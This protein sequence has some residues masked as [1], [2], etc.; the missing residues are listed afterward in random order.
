M[1][2]NFGGMIFHNYVSPPLSDWVF[3]L[4]LQ[5]A[6]WATAAIANTWLQ[7]ELF[8]DL[9]KIKVPTL[10]LHGLNDQVCLFPLA[11]AQKE[12]IKN[13]RLIPF[14]SCGHFLFYDQ[15]ERFNEELVKFAEG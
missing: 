13:A 11:T 9:G 4:G 5:A 2:R 12:G 1:L 7:E 15:M 10:I 8:Q 3:E 14:E 6:S